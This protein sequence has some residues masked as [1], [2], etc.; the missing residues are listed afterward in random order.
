MRAVTEA[1]RDEA[2]A[3]QIANSGDM[4]REIFYLNKEP[5]L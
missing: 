3:R 5:S 1:T 4:R 2:E